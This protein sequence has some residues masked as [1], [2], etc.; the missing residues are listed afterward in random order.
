MFCDLADS[1]Q[2][3][4]QLDLEDLR[5]VLRAYQQASVAVIERFEGYVAQYL[6]DG[7]LVYFGWPQAHEDDAQRAVHAGVGIL[8]AMDTLNARLAADKGLRLAVRLG[9]HTGPV[10]VGEMGA[11]GRHEQ[12]ALGETPNVAARLQALAAG[13]TVAV[14]ATTWRLVEGYFTAEALGQHTLKGVATP[15]AVSRILATSGVQSRLDLAPTRGLTPLIGRE[16]E[17][18]TLLERWAQVKDGQGQVILLSGDAGIGKSRLLQVLKD[19]VA[20]APHTMLECRSSPYSQHTAFYP[21]TELWART[22]DFTRD[23]P[24]EATLDTAYHS[25]LRSTRQQVHARI[26]QAL[27]GQFPE[28]AK[29]QPELLAHHFLY[30]HDPGMGCHIIIAQTLWRLGY[31]DQALRH[32]Q[33]ALK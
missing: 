21:L 13:D 8:E 12:L 6:G 15:M 10:V 3:S 19:H 27:E 29:T 28:I 32:N 33:E 2:L 7:L 20:Q 9:V 16:S 17:V 30:G 11:G 1:T 24:A 18:A 25:M 26:A 22:W 4:G 31:P 23:D 5:T 14:S